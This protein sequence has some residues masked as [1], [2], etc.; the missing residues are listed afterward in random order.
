[1]ATML[2]LLAAGKP[3]RLAMAG[4]S[5][6]PLLREPMVLELG[7]VRDR[8]RLGDVLVFALDDKL[9]AHRVVDFR[10]GAYLTAGDNTPSKLDRVEPERI[11]GRVVAVYADRSPGARRIDGSWYRLR[12]GLKART[13]ALRVFGIGVMAQLRRLRRG[14]DAVH[15]PRAF[16]ALFQAMH[17]ILH[18][19]RAE[20]QVAI[21]LVPP[22]SLLATARRHKCAGLLLNGM[23]ALD[24]DLSSHEQLVR[25][26][27]ISNS[28]TAV[29]LFRLREQIVTLVSIL[30]ASKLDFVLLKGASR[31]YGQDEDAYLHESCDID[32]LVKREDVDAAVAALRAAGYFQRER[33]RTTAWYT[34]Y[35]HH[36][37]P[38]SDPKGE[39]TIEV[40]IALAPP[41][42]LDQVL[43]WNSLSRHFRTIEG[44]AGEARCLND[45]GTAIHLAAHAI[46]LTPLRDVVI[47]AQLLQRLD[48]KNVSFFKGFVDGE[49]VESVRLDAVGAMAARLADFAWDESRA[50]RRYL[51]WVTRRE[52]LP[53]FIRTRSGFTDVRYSAKDPRPLSAFI[54]EALHKVDD[55]HRVSDAIKAP[56]RMIGRLAIGGVAYLYA[57][58]LPPIVGVWDDLASFG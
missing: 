39:G 12:G 10:G 3:A 37:A 45:V 21:E 16:A 55:R 7:A 34:R 47:L 56:F 18:R 5:M 35:H 49:T 44:P 13:R 9:C 1:M 30:R 33:G 50:V 38:F 22:E 27:R 54:R 42:R 29:K 46:R 26:L 53:D 4:T 32:V 51:A 58:A 28:A 40:H 14:L 20:L 15:R 36:V 48:A 25:G 41:G 11:I 24:I 57:R 6:L 31:I 8:V 23:H 19:D 2:M 17:A 52:D 43:D